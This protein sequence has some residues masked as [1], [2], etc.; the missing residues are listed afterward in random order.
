M[1]LKPN[2]IHSSY[3]FALIIHDTH[4]NVELQ[5][6]ILFIPSL[7]AAVTLVKI[8]NRLGEFNLYTWSFVNIF[9]M[10]LGLENSS[11]AINSMLEAWLFIL[12]SITGF[13]FSNEISEA[14]TNLL[15]AERVE[16]KFHR[17]SN[18]AASNLT[19]LVTLHPSKS[20]RVDNDAIE[21]ERLKANV[22]FRRVYHGENITKSYRDLFST[23]Q[24]AM[25]FLKSPLVIPWVVDT[26]NFGGR[27]EVKI[28]SLV[29]SKPVASLRIKAFSPYY[30]RIS[31]L[32]WRFVETGDHNRC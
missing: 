12:V 26:F 2:S 9:K 28:T 10:F 1:R 20:F 27:P 31:E 23:R 3:V 16:L 24:C 17:L 25:T 6:L 19:L 21:E 29:V 15:N 18:L 7:V 32:S 22:R 14:A 8:C 4:Y 13:F 5:Q 11:G 30:E